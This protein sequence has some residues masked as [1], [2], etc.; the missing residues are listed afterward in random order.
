[1][2]IWLVMEHD[3][4][5]DAYAENVCAVRVCPSQELAEEWAKA[6]TERHAAKLAKRKKAVKHLSYR[7]EGRTVTEYGPHD[8]VE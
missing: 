1:M 5:A 7:V 2:T 4:F 6:L 3:G 8:L